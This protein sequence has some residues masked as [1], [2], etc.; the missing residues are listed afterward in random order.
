MAIDPARQAELFDAALDFPAAERPGFLDRACAGDL[1]LRAAV[2]ALLR[3]DVDAE[4][5]F[6][7]TQPSFA[8]ELPP[9]RLGRY[10]LVR[11]VGEGGMGEV[12]AARDL[13][14]GRDV[15]LKL[16]H[17]RSEGARELLVREGLILARLSHANIVPL[18]DIGEHDDLVYL[19][20]ELVDGVSLRTWLKDPPRDWRLRLAPLLDAA[21]GLAAAHD[22]GYLHGDVKPDNV[23]VGRDGRVRVV[24]FGLA[25]LVDQP[26]AAPFGGTPAYM[27]PELGGAAG[28]TTR[29]DQ[30]SF[31]V[32]AH[33]CLH[34]A[35]PPARD[36]A[37]EL[38]ER[39]EAALRR[40]LDPAPAA[41]FPTMHA[42]IAELEA[43]LGRDPDTDLSIARETRRAVF[44]A[45]LVVSALVD[46]V[47]H[48]RGFGR[49]A[50]DAADLLRLA[51]FSAAAI[52]LAVAIAWPRLRTRINR[53]LAL[54]LLLVVAAM[55]AHRLIA[56]RFGH[57][58]GEILAVDLALIGSLAALTGLLLQTWLFVP[59]IV[60]L[61]GAG[62]SAYAPELAPIAMSVGVWTTA[63]AAIVA[64]RARAA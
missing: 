13:L 60:C 36:P 59:A 55:S 21:R 33:E 29:A 24:D 11:R 26:D 39:L 23:L 22:L 10:E 9:A 17:A 41:R 61:A 7:A 38:P 53:R 19:A 44:L 16:L 43:V 64:F 12:H 8:P 18:Y 52:G 5:A 62:V 45:L 42:L 14:L 2:D 35:R 30:Y 1:A 47:V 63:L 20:M 54:V 34:G 25:R 56:A 27:A 32:T 3:A 31:C 46:L 40:G 28:L 4:P 49:P 48:V 58:G 6:L 15:A 51:G 57:P 37:L 50:P